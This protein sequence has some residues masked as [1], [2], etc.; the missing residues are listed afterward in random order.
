[1]PHM[2]RYS[3]YDILGEEVVLLS[4]GV[5]HVILSD[6]KGT[7][8]LAS[9]YEIKAMLMRIFILLKIQDWPSIRKEGVFIAQNM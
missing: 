3:A 1:M 8:I 9:A 7:L 4:L 6:Q 2:S 5:G